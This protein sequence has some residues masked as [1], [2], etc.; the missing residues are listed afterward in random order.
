M[1]HLQT[2][3]FVDAIAKAGSIRQ[4]AKMLSITQS[5][6]NRRI[7]ALE[8]ELGVPIFERLPRGVRLSTAGEILIHHIRAQISDMD[9]IQS[10]IADLSGVRRGHVAVAC[11]QALIP[12]FM[13]EQIARYRADHPGVTFSV[14]MRDRDAAEQALLDYSADVA[15]VFE[16]V[17]LSDFETL[18]VVRQPVFAMMSRS[19]PLAKRKT[20]TL[21]ECLDYPLALPSTPYGVR[22]ILETAAARLNLKLEPVVQSDSFEFLRNFVNLDNAIAFQIPIG[23]PETST[24]SDIVAAPLDQGDMPVG[25][26]HLAHLRGRVLPVAAARFMDQTFAHFAEKYEVQ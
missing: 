5:A 4:A 26:L 7:L 17:R 3:R 11:S 15:I 12:F 20:A 14:L 21:V 13:P 10:H 16:P 8:D 9:R 24:S 2:F 25:R 23:L 19:H 18:L 22:S 6:L 1:R